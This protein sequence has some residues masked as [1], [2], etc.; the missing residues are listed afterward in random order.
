MKRQNL[1]C[2]TTFDDGNN[3]PEEMIS[4]DIKSGLD[5]IGVSLHCQI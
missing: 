4:A 2:H 3:S 1:H 5:C